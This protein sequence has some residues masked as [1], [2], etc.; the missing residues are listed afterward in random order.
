MRSGSVIPFRGSRKL[1]DASKPMKLIFHLEKAFFTSDA[2][3]LRI[4]PWSTKT[5]VSLS[6]TASASSA[7]HTEESTPP[8]RASSTLPSPTLVLISSMERLQ[9]SSMRQF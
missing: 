2:S 5:Q 3:F 4:M 6:P 8:D 7:A 1:S 9:K